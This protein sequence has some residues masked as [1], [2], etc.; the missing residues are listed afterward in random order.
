MFIIFNLLE[1]KDSYEIPKTEIM[2]LLIYN[3]NSLYS[4]KKSNPIAL[5]MQVP[6]T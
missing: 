4:N 3:L 6:C 5:A 2:S 1:I